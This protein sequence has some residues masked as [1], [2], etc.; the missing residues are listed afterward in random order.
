MCSA[1]SEKI[2]EGLKKTKTISLLNHVTDDVIKNFV[3]HFIL[4][5]HSKMFILIGCSVLHMQLW[6]H[7]EGTCDVIKITLIPH[8][9]Y[10]LCA[11]F[12]IFPWCG[13]RDTEVQSFSVFPIW[14]PHHVTYEIIIIETFHMSSHTN[15]ENFISIWQAVVEKTMKVL[16]G[17][18]D[19]QTQTNGPKCNT[20]SSNPSARVNI[21]RYF[22]FSS[23]I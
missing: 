2:F 8:E 12:Q 3:Y 10:L 7:S 15:G 5:W 20:P 23:Q 11:K 6:C 4:R 9:E 17:Q 19:R 18:T 13:F 14:L 22:L 1:I 21:T 16:C